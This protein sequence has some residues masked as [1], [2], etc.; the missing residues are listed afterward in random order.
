M[1]SALT[2]NLELTET[3]GTSLEVE[4][5]EVEVFVV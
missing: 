5:A 1:V 2:W 4:I 3:G